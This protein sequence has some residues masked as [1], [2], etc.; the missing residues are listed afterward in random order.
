MNLFVLVMV[1]LSLY[2]GLFTLTLFILSFFGKEKKTFKDIGQPYVSILI[3]AYN[4]QAALQ[5]TVESAAM[6]DYPKNKFEIIIIDDG[7][8]DR[9]SKISRELV[10]KYE[11]VKYYLKKNGGKG[12]A[13]NFGIKRSKGSFIVTL[14]AD[15][16]VNSD[17]L[18]LMVPHFSNPMVM[19][20]TNAMKVYKPK[21]F[22]QRIQA[23]EYD[24]GIFFR[25]SFANM[26]GINVTPGPF[27]II[28]K[29]FFRKYGGYDE[30]NLTEDMEMAMRIQSHNYLIENEPKAIVYTVAPRNFLSLLKQRRR[31]YVGTINIWRSYKGLF[32]KSFGE[33]GLFVLPLAII[34]VV[35]TLSVTIYYVSRG[36]IDSFRNF[37][38]YSKIGYD[39][40][41]NMNFQIYYVINNLYNSLSEGVFFFAAFFAIFTVI[42]LIFLNKKIGSG[43]NV[44][45]T[46]INYLL[47]MFVYGILYSFWW[48]IAGLYSISGRRIKW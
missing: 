28:R 10:K 26:Q 45:R 22:F 5:K 9:T 44:I 2:L 21:T 30:H 7:S 23:I 37:M 41:N 8:T 3:P 35:T 40:F 27:S 33:F 29:T 31:W 34:S 20:V 14:D 32:G 1:Y 12:S 19:A 17:A 15:S 18:K 39:F 47:F 16:F 4:E 48:A 36:L 42:L 46:F 11:N 24:L 25:K 43:E 38:L 13:L 6:L